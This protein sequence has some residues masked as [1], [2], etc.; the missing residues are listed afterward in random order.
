MWGIPPWYTRVRVEMKSGKGDDHDGNADDKEGYNGV[1]LSC[2][3]LILTV[4]HAT[5]KMLD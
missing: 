2:V 1:V 4:G 3:T 5:C